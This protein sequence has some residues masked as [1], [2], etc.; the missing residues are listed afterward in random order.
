[1]QK[2]TE[3]KT[4]LNLKKHQ[5]IQ[6]CIKCGP[7]EQALIEE[8]IQMLYSLLSVKQIEY[9]EG[10]KEIPLGFR[11]FSLLDMEVGVADMQGVQQV[12]QLTQLEQD[13]AAKMHYLQT[14]KQTLI[15]LSNL[16]VVDE[17]RLEEREDEY[18]LVKDQI[19]ILERKIQ[20]IK[21]QKK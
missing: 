15:M 12:D 7:Q 10:T 8:N 14:V 13:L 16:P 19:S 1:M 5:P 17:A 20:Q 21:M 9:T 2:I 6:L 11:K 18:E 4:L 3:Q